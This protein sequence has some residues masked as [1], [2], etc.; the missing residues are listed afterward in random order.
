MLRARKQCVRQQSMWCMYA[1]SRAS[2]LRACTYILFVI[3]LASYSAFVCSAHVLL[4]LLRLHHVVSVR[5]V[6]STDL[7]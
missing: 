6:R 7:P 2:T 3:S 5:C 1:S 4:L